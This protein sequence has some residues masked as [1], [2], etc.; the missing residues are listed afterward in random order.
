MI[1]GFVKIKAQAF[2]GNAFVAKLRSCGVAFFR[3]A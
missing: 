1:L 2:G 3:I